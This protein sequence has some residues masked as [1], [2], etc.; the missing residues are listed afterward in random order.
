MNE[1]GGAISLFVSRDLT[2][3]DSVF[4]DNVAAGTAL[5]RGGAIDNWAG[6][7]TVTLTNV[8]FGAGP[9]GNAPFDY[10]TPE[11]DI[12]GTVTLTCTGVGG[13]Q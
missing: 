5:Q 9:T 13:C 4:E 6:G 2:I 1:R 11:Q 3:I 10:A 7:S 8:T 12:T